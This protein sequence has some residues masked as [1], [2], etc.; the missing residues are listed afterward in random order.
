MS[1]SA[2]PKVLVL[3]GATASGKTALSLRLASALDAEIISADSRQIYRELTIGTAKPSADELA[4]VPHHFI[5]ELSLPTAYD[6]GAFMVDARARLA[7]VFARGKM[8]LVVG[9]STLYLQGLTQGFAELPKSHPDIRQRLYAELATLGKEALY[10]RLQTLDPEQAQTLDPTKTQRLIRSLEVIEITGRKLSELKQHLQPAPFEFVFVGL[11]MPREK[12]Y[13]R[14]NQRLDAMVKQGLIDEARM[15]YERFGKTHQS[16]KINALET[17]GYKELFEHF[18]GKRA[19][20]E[21]LALIK[22]HT[23]NYAKR[24][25]TFFRNK[26]KVTWIDAPQTEQDIAFAQQRVISIFNP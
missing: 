26:F 10:A 4:C 6:A 5:N 8:P 15:L 19:L 17:V 21:T 3:I 24:Q 22:Q 13:E 25:L 23:R 14:I 2:L 12:L 7:D 18:R 11:D 20:A 1:Q 9:G 16:K